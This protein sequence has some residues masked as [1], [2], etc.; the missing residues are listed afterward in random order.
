[1]FQSSNVTR[2]SYEITL[3]IA[4]QKKTY[5]IGGTLVKPV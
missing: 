3:L 2:A 5:T 4:K 1:M